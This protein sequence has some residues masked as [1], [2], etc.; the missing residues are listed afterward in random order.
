MIVV[1]I[2]LWP[3][4]VEEK[5][6][7]LARL[8]IARIGSST[9]TRASYD[10]AIMRRGETRSPWRSGWG[11]NANNL[12]TPL[13][14]GIVSDYARKAYPVVQL[15]KLAIETLYPSYPSSRR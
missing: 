6:K 7:E 5:A 9:P 3:S 13:R 2:E 12:A 14:R 1:K 11:G 15:V 10:V 4:G 8:Y